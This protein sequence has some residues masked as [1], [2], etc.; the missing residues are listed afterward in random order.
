MNYIFLISGI[1]LLNLMRLNEARKK[2]DFAWKYFLLNNGIPAMCAFIL[3]IT[4]ILSKGV[5]QSSYDVSMGG[6]TLSINIYVVIGIAADVILKKTIGAFNP[7]K[8]TVIGIN[9]KEE[10]EV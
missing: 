2:P 4:L 6:L 10:G 7:E 1:L 3:G 5:N 9:K 8:S